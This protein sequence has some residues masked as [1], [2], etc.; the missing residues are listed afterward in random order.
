MKQQTKSKLTT[1]LMI[2]ALLLCIGLFEVY[3]AIG[4]LLL[5][6]IIFMLRAWGLKNII[7]SNIK[8]AEATIFGKPLDKDI[9]DKGEMKNTKIVMTKSKANWRDIF[10]KEMLTALFW[11]GLLTIVITF[12]LVW[13]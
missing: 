13:K 1:T 11:G 9:W 6:A 3:G 7:S 10:S 2:A 12:W 5:L 4:F 8:N